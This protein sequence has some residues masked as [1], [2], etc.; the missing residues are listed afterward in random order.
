MASQSPEKMMAAVTESMRERT[1]RTLEEWVSLVAAS[2]VDPLDQ[3]AVRRWLKSEHGIPQNSRWA[4]ADAAAR[5]AGWERPETEEYIDQQYSGA[6]AGLRSIFDR[7]RAAI[8][9]LGDDV[10]M[11]GRSTYTPFVRRRQFVALAAA[12]RSRVDVGLRYTEAPRSK[13]LT[14][15]TA[16]GQ[17]T[18]KLSL[19][20]PEQVTEEVERLLRVAYDQNG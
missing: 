19:T 6:K 8:D 12:T 10:T 11:E 4:I 15:A 2:E 7:L 18:H 17:A 9:V 16:P 14:S 20:A 13:L 3:N 1:G 5:A